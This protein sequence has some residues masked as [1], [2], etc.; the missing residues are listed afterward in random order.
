MTSGSTMVITFGNLNLSRCQ[1]IWL[2]YSVM[3]FVLTLYVLGSVFPVQLRSPEWGFQLSTT[4]L[5]ETLIPGWV[6]CCTGLG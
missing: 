3:M 5:N 4:V 2:A 1:V 6:A